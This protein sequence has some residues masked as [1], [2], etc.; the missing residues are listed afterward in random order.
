LG[1]VQNRVQYAKVIELIHESRAHGK[2]IAGGAASLRPGY[3]VRPTIFRD[4]KEGARIVDE[5]QFGPV[6]PIIRY[7]DAEDVVRRANAT[8]YGLGG[9][10]WS[11]N[12]ERAYLL[13]SK[14]NC[15]VV[16]IN[17]HG[18]GSPQFPFAGA[19][20]SGFGVEL[21]EEGLAEFTQIQ[22]VNIQR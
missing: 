4:I 15:G 19:N 18:D 7:S 10:I 6:L 21:G 8:H 9:S 2:L 1:P 3:F 14:L 12:P 5:E 13:A 17:K 11:S 16:W 20:E 22:V